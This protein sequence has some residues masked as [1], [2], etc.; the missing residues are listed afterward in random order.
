M[1]WSDAH[2]NRFLIHGT[3]YGVPQIGGLMFLTSS[4]KPLSEFDFHVGERF[5]YEYDLHDSWMDHIP[6]GG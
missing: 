2:Q 5:L 3:W 4:H 6:I 1:G